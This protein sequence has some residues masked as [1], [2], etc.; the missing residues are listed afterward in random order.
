VEYT[1]NI[2]HYLGHEWDGLSVVLNEKSLVITVQRWDRA[3]QPSYH[4][5]LVVMYIL[6]FM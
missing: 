3:T 1:H 2:D 5:T 4:Y 6:G